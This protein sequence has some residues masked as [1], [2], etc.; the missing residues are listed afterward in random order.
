MSEIKT[1]LTNL[2]EEKGKSLETGIEIEGHFGMTYQNLV[3][4]IEEVPTQMQKDIRTMLVKIDFHN[5]DVFH[6]LNHLANGMAKQAEANM[7]F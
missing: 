7:G 5:G 3:D 4:F 2:I 1:Y 6:Y